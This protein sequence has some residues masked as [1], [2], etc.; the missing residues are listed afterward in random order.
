[1]KELVLGTKKLAQALCTP[2]PNGARPAAWDSS[3]QM[4]ALTRNATAGI[5]CVEMR[6]ASVSGPKNAQDEST[7][8][9]GDLSSDTYVKIMVKDQCFGTLYI[10]RTSHYTFDT[11]PRK[12][13]NLKRSISRKKSRKKKKKN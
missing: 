5:K 12:P 6:G 3:M 8:C 4:K 7:R 9:V 1:M 10:M 11:Y 2:R 13:V